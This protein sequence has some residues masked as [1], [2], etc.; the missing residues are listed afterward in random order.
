MCTLSSKW[1]Q[2]VPASP[3]SSCMNCL[4]LGG[5][6]NCFLANHK[7]FSKITKILTKKAQTPLTTCK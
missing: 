7:I 2:E 5:N 4:D 3:Q 6:H 1:L